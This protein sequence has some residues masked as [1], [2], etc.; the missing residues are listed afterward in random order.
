MKGVDDMNAQTKEEI[1]KPIAG[2]VGLYDVSNLGRVR[3]Y[4]TFGCKK[5]SATG[6]RKQASQGSSCRI[7]K[8]V[9]VTKGYLKVTLRKCNTSEDR[10]ISQLV[11]ETFAGKPIVYYIDGDK[12]N[13]AAGNLRYGS[14]GEA[15]QRN[16]ELNEAVG[17]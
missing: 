5:R 2:Y 3:S 17:T 8:P 15:M 10:F 7:L 16:K 11:L 6:K 14:I 4:H 12:T 9:A 1:W 13:L